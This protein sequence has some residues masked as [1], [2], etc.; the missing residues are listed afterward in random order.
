MKKTRISKHFTFVAFLS[1][2]A[3]FTFIIQAS[4]NK[5]VNPVTQVKK[6]NTIKPL[7]PNLDQDTLRQIETRQE[8]FRQDLADPILTATPSSSSSPLL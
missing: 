6:N 3:I 7:D 8:F 4:Y 2:L 5:L 1:F